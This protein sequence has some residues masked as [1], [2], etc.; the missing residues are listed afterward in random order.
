M[1]IS[2]DG[3]SDTIIIDDPDF[4][5]Q[6]NPFYIRIPGMSKWIHVAIIYKDMNIKVYVDGVE[7]DSSEGL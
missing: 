2:F 4:N 7:L 5:N 3:T 6:I 1:I